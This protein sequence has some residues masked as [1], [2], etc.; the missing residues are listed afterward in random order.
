MTN[1]IKSC[2]IIVTVEPPDSIGYVNVRTKVLDESTGELMRTRSVE[3]NAMPLDVAAKFAK[4]RAYDDAEELG[5]KHV[6]QYVSNIDQII[7]N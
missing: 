5:Y 1:E 3:Y 6:G 2:T 7:F 4:D